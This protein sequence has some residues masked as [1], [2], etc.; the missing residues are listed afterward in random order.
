M[1]SDSAQQLLNAA[2]EAL[3]SRG[4]MSSLR[5]HLQAELFQALENQPPNSAATPPE[6]QL[7]NEL[8][9]EYLSFSHY[10]YT[11]SVF[12]SEAGL[13]GGARL[14]RD[15][16]SSMLGIAPPNSDEQMWVLQA[17]TT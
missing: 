14:R 8:I 15:T 1:E 2:N 6:T 11:L 4:V 16:A 3:E 12:M 13:K 7:I 9:C 17:V 10:N 5:A